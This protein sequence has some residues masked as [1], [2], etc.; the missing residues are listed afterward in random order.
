MQRIQNEK[1][2]IEIIQENRKYKCENNFLTSL[3]P[4]C[5]K[6]TGLETG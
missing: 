4:F 1:H 3:I 2:M 5:I 6:D